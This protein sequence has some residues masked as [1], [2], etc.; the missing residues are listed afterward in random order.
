MKALLLAVFTLL[1]GSATAIEQPV[2]IL[3]I[4]DSIT[5]GGKGYPSYRW[6]LAPLLKENG[7]RAE[8]IG[9]HQDRAGGHFGNG[10]RNTAW[11]NERT[12]EVYTRHPADIVL[13]HSGHNS[14]S[15]DK[16][17]P[18]I[19]R[20][21]EAM[22]RAIH[23]INPEA[24]VLLAQ[25][26]ESGKLPKYGYIPEL[27]RKLPELAA[28]L[29]REGLVVQPVDLAACFNWKT[30]A[31]EDQVHPNEEGAKKMAR[32]WLKA[33]TAVLKEPSR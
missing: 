2:T 17:V 30:D 18:G 12:R 6:F 25:V 33:L 31:V 13:I 19:L 8:F 23:A 9:P 21:T 26:I 5:A 1:A 4:G 22:I 32:A 10:G 16:P 7:I 15:K 29:R 14:F 24:K 11:L 20:D 28:T 3:C 27:N